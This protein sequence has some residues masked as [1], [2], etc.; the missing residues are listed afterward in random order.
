MAIMLI[1][2]AGF[3]QTDLTTGKTV[4][5]YLL[6]DIQTQLLS[7]NS[8]A[9]TTRHEFTSF[10]RPT[11]AYGWTDKKNRTHELE[12]TELS[13][14]KDR[15]ANTSGGSAPFY[16]GTIYRIRTAIRYEYRIY[17]LKNKE[18]KLNP[19]V[20]IGVMG[21]HLRDD[22]KPEVSNIYRY[23]NNSTGILVHIIPRLQYKLS[24][25][26]YADLNFPVGITNLIREG[27]RIYNPALKAKEQTF[28]T[29]SLTTLP[30]YFCV[31]LG[32][33]ILL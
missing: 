1:P 20:G 10:I 3:S 7:V 32:A 19:S 33:G 26:V 22:Y 21:Y 27:N 29:F 25:H 6:S 8:G 5:V 30:E 16:A 23:R 12:L 15:E 28:S 18:C 4:K 2:C 17:L 11:V 31:R 13:F 9:G 14:T 24:S